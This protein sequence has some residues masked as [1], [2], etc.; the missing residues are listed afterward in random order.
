MVVQKHHSWYY[1][2]MTSVHHTHACIWS[3]GVK[4]V[5]SR[6]ALVNKN[7]RLHMHATFWAHSASISSIWSIKDPLFY[8]VCF[9]LSSLIPVNCTLSAWPSHLRFTTSCDNTVCMG[10]CTSHGC[11]HTQWHGEELPYPWNDTQI[12]DWN[13][14]TASLYL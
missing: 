13:K 8:Y 11:S 7:T 3:S 5:W 12:K 9:I 14:C 6:P 2:L 4:A 1:T 10:N